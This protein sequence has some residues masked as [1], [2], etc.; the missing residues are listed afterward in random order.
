VKDG[1]YVKASDAIAED[2]S[3]TYY[4]VDQLLHYVRANDFNGAAR[5][6]D[7]N[8]I[9]INDLSQRFGQNAL[10]AAVEAQS[11][12]MVR[13]LLAYPSVQL[14]IPTSH[15]TGGNTPLHIAAKTGNLEIALLLLKKGA[16][17]NARNARKQT[18]LMLVA[19]QPKAQTVTHGLQLGSSATC[20]TQ[21]LG[22][23]AGLNTV[24]GLS[25]S[26]VNQPLPASALFTLVAQNA[27]SYTVTPIDPAAEREAM[28]VKLLMAY[29]ADPSITDEL[30]LDAFHMASA[31]SKTRF[32]AQLHASTAGNAAAASASATSMD[33]GVPISSTT[34]GKVFGDTSCYLDARALQATRTRIPPPQVV[35][36]VPS[37]TGSV[38]PTSTSSG[39]SSAD[40]LSSLTNGTEFVDR[41]DARPKSANTSASCTALPEPLRAIRVV[42]AREVANPPSENITWLHSE[43]VFAAHEQ[44]TR[45]SAAQ[46]RQAWV[47]T[48]AKSLVFPDSLSGQANPG[49]G[50]SSGNKQPRR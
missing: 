27:A 47:T 43:N 8:C 16:N 40:Q 7:A 33:N 13:F 46:A 5:I 38:P 49:D 28:M 12:D 10:H 31:Q 19:Q 17:P 39:I 2:K 20:A 37:A 15:A 48:N 50:K 26:R 23:V 22:S 35:Y 11:L 42:P 44:A 3:S 34:S 14:E 4:T 25:I 6:V 30:G 9:N 45:Q 36:A 18:P 1:Y 29:G 21:K 41:G 24:G 32:L